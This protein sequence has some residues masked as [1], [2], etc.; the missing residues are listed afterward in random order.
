MDGV[1]Q[2]SVLLVGMEQC[3][4]WHGSNNVRPTVFLQVQA[5][6][7]ILK[8]RMNVSSTTALG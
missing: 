4:L 6:S 5:T 7:C 8:A 3:E 2:D 1:S